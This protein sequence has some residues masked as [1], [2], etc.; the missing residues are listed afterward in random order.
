MKVKY[1]LFACEISDVLC[2]LFG[3]HLNSK[4]LIIANWF[5][6]YK[7]TNSRWVCKMISNKKGRKEGIMEGRKERRKE[8]IDFS[9]ICRFKK[10]AQKNL[11]AENGLKWFSGCFGY[12]LIKFVANEVDL[13]KH[14]AGIRSFQVVDKSI[15]EGGN[16]VS[17][18]PMERTRKRK[19]G[20]RTCHNSRSNNK[21]SE[22]WFNDAKYLVATGLD[23]PFL[24]CTY[25]SR[26]QQIND[27]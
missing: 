20:F 14:R 10:S 22:Y 15:V 3:T 11:L 18:F 5:K 25:R 21:S 13:S 17:K 2:A 9:L 24:T 4:P 6:F 19:G 27:Q 16:D 26:L 23:L 12:S 1:T 8:K 7:R